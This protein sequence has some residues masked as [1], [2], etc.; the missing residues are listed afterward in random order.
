MALC[1]ALSEAFDRMPLTPEADDKAARFLARVN[2]SEY[3]GSRHHTVPRF[4]LSRWATKNKAA[5]Y[6]RV[7][8]AFRTENVRQPGDQRLLHVHR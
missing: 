3:V 2:P 4:L 5:V 7:E 6:H 1:A 8:S